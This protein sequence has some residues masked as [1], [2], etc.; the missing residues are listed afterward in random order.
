MEIITKNISYTNAD[1]QDFNLN[2]IHDQDCLRFE[3]FG[4]SNNFYFLSSE[5]VDE[6]IELLKEKQK[7]IWP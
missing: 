3:I 7:E 2:K 1:N 5:E 4:G 6:F